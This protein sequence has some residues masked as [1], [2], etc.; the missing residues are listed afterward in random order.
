MDNDRHRRIANGRSGHQALLLLLLGAVM[1]LSVP[2]AA[3]GGGLGAVLGVPLESARG[4]LVDGQPQPDEITGDPRENFLYGSI[5]AENEA[6]IPYWVIAVL[7]RIFKEYMPGPGGYAAFGLPWEEGK[8]FPAGFSKKTVIFPRVGFNCALCHSTQYRTSAE[9]SPVV[10][11]AGGSNTADIEGLLDFFTKAANDP[12]FNAGTI[13]R[14][15]DASYPLRWYDRLL[16]R[17]VI[18]IVRKRLI[19]QGREFAWT[20]E[21]P[22][23]GPGRDAPMN[24]TKFNFLRMPLD[25]SVDHT[26]FPSIWHLAAREQ[27][28]RTFEEGKTPSPV[29]AHTMLMNL[30]GATTSFRS[31]LIDSALGLGARNTPFFRA[32]IPQLLDWLRELRPPAYPLAID[33]AK[34]ARGA[35]VFEAN[36]ASCH[37]SGRNNREGTV[38]PI[39]EVGTD[40][41]RLDTWRHTG[42]AAKANAKVASLGIKRTPMIETDGYIAVQLDGIWLRGPYLHNGSVPTMRDLLAPPD[43]RPKVFCRGYDVIDKEGLGFISD[44]RVDPRCVEGSPPLKPSP[45]DRRLPDGRWDEWPRPRVWKY[46]V[47]ER[48]N[49]NGGHD[50]GTRLSA[51]E[52]DD[53]I[54]YLKTL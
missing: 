27:P 31:V 6:G 51:A 49:G 12:R 30:D 45:W 16:Y 19:Q 36:C 1:A 43:R 3:A 52:K 34:A 18:P 7:P 54:E 9:S 42:A 50:Y 8:E 46:Y 11:A 13:L 17:L 39:E 32:R 10:V 24:L 38:I 21:R 5:G 41:E 22:R 15:V 37:A 2:L 40:P 20:A 23:W 25:K 44:E 26:D 14:E 4:G 35:S 47:S 28:G 48:G 33:G 53:L 29:P